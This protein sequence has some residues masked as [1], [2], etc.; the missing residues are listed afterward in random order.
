MLTFTGCQKT[1]QIKPQLVFSADYTLEYNE[2]QI[3]GTLLAEDDGN[4]SISV[5]SPKTLKGLFA[6]TD[7]ENFEVNYNG[8]SLSYSKDNLPD[9][10]FFKMILIS[11]EKI[12]TSEQLDFEKVEDKYIATE[13][14]ALGDVEITLDENFYIEKIEIPTQGFYLKLKKTR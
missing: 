1:A 5:T 8:I 6:K 7:G 14:T 11:L 12:K 10:V 4:V 2:M 13:S 3:K 9:G